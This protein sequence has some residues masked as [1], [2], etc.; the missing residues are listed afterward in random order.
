MTPKPDDLLA[1]QPGRQRTFKI[2]DLL[3]D[4]LDKLCRLVTV[5]GT[6]GT[7]QRQDLLEVLIADAPETVAELDQLVH[8]YR[9]KKVRDALVGDEKN[10]T[11]IQLRPV[12][13]GRRGAG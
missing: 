3:S 7:I 4:R 2:A 9:G 10:A 13:P 8:E 1:K 12:R 5:D 6:V 11:V